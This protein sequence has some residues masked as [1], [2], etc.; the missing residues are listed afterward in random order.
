MDMAPPRPP[1]L[2]RSGLAFSDP[3]LPNGLW[4]V[5]STQYGSPHPCLQQIELLPLAGSPERARPTTAAVLCC[6][7]GGLV[8]GAW[9][10]L[11]VTPSPGKCWAVTVVHCSLVRTKGLALGR[12]PLISTSSH[13][14]CGLVP[15]SSHHHHT[16]PSGRREHCRDC[17]YSRFFSSSPT[18][19][20]SPSP[21]SPP[22]SFPLLSCLSG[23]RDT[24]DGSEGVSWSVDR[25][26]FPLLLV[27]LFL[28]SSSLSLFLSLRPAR[29][30]TT[31]RCS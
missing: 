1:S 22:P 8:L 28:D 26:R 4:R 7:V 13:F 18:P 10:L 24:R 12:P 31:A 11:Y 19:V 15:H 3:C 5:L 2:P 25:S 20:P 21:L 27:P 23:T 30:T 29:T 14:L 6:A 9:C 17:L 16:T